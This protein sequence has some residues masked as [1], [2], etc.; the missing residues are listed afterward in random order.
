MPWLVAA[1]LYTQ[2]GCLTSSYA[3][4]ALACAASRELHSSGTVRDSNPLPRTWNAYVMFFERTFMETS[5]TRQSNDGHQPS[6]KLEQPFQASF[7]NRKY[8]FERRKSR[9][10]QHEFFQICMSGIHIYARITTCSI[11]RK[12]PSTNRPNRHFSALTRSLFA[13][14][15][16]LIASRVYKHRKSLGFERASG[17]CEHPFTTEARSGYSTLKES[18]SSSHVATQR[19]QKRNL[20]PACA[21]ACARR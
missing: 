9:R 5:R 12:F 7:K 15:S 8:G 17:S 11:T 14:P 3:P 20:S 4:A 18:R 6:A 13:T 16:V 19:Q 2:D 10:F 21:T 1:C